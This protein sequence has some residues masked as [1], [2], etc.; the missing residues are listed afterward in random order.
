MSN[1]RS[2]SFAADL[3]NAGR[4]L[5]MG[6]ADIIPGVSGG[7]VALILGIYERLL[8]ALGNFDL[9]LVQL[10]RHGRWRQAGEHIDLRFLLALGAGIATGIVGLASTMHYLLRYHSEVT[11]AFFF[12]LILGSTY[13]VARWVRP[14]SASAV[15]AAIAGAAFA[16]WLVGQLPT[17][18]PPGYWY[19]FVCGAVAICAMILPGISGAFI[20]VIMG[21]YFHVTGI[22]KETLG[23]NVSLE[24][25]L[26]IAIFG[27]GCGVGLLSFSKF[28]RWL[29]HRHEA[30]TM[31][32]L[33]GFMLGS[34]R[35]IWPFKQDMTT[36]AHL[37]RLGLPEEKLAQFREAPEQLDLQYRLLENRLPAALTQEVWLIFALMIAGVALVLVLDYFSRATPQALPLKDEQP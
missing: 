9:T 4:G 30:L 14:C 18:P 15:F 10:V 32:T 22:L 11:W 33:G 7:T 31:A 25:L 26:M 6:G 21:M 27:A 12:G 24:S 16:Y 3:K 37:Q 20:L 2:Q 34:L 36:L 23:G 35:K 29:L 19:V 8:G 13:L 17:T 5:L 1:P 28:L